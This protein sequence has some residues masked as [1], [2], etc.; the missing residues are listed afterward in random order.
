M[1]R[2]L[3]K[4]KPPIALSPL[5]TERE[6]RQ[7][8]QTVLETL[9]LKAIRLFSVPMVGFGQRKAVVGF[10]LRTL[11]GLNLTADLRIFDSV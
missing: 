6:D 7:H 5:E 1:R 4:W 10:E 2:I 9:C 11:L 8:G 3:T